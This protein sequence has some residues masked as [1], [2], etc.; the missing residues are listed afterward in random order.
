MSIFLEISLVLVLATVVA[1]I[2]RLFKQPLIMGH[3]LTGII[4]GTVL[5]AQTHS[6]ETIEIFSEFGVATLLF[7]VGLHLS[8]KVA[9]EV[10]KV[11]ALVGVGQVLFTSSIGYFASLA[12][13]FDNISAIYIGLAITFSSTIIVLK[14]LSDKHDIEKLYGKISIGLLL[15]Q[16]IFAVLSLIFIT[17]FANGSSAASIALLLLIKGVVVG[18]VL[19]IISIYLLPLLENFFA[20]SQ[21]FLF[22]FSLG[23]GFGMASLFSYIGFSIEIGALIAGVALSVSPYSHEISSKLKP[24]RDFFIIMF[25]VFLGS[26]FTLEGALD[27]IGPITFFTLFILLAEPFIIILL[28]SYFG[29]NKKTSFFTGVAMA[30]VSEFSLILVLLGVKVGHISSNVLTLITLLALITIAFSTYL[31]NFA[32]RI[33]PLFIGFLSKLEV[34]KPVVARDIISKYDVVLFG[35][36]RIGFDFLT[37]FKE[38]GQSFLVVDFDPNIVESLNNMGI[39]TRYGDAEDVELLDEIQVASANMVVSTIPEYDINELLITTIKSKNTDAI[40][41]VICHD[42]DD[43]LRLYSK[44]ANYVILPHFIGG[45]FA[46]LLA[47]KHGFAVDKFDKERDRQIKALEARKK[48]GHKHPTRE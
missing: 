19:I 43:A 20:K 36:N 18:G 46:A 37:M 17:A 1:G 29:Y 7:I 32:G 12:L 21:E 9:R 14:I 45:H 11:S 13:G 42:V 15:V 5:F 34:E 39:N 8:P 3:I 6:K 23:W 24:L 31:I 44:G 2:M 47:A 4:A 38:L 10:G 41:I 22:I 40:V 48:M 25:F 33:Y 35:C 28:L 26:Q 16:D 30:Q 27:L